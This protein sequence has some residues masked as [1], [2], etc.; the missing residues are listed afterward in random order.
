MIMDRA[1]GWCLNDKCED[2]LKGVF[3]INSAG[4]YRCH[5][6]LTRGK[7]ES[8]T[9]WV[10]GEGFGW[11][12]VRVEY[13]FTPPD[14]KYH[15]L[16]IIRDDCR[17][18]GKVYHFR[19]SIVKTDKRATT[20]ATAMLGSLQFVDNLEEGERPSGMQQLISWDDP[21]EKYE[22]DLKE[23]EIRWSKSAAM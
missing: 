4:H 20:I 7:V 19:S 10:E 23:L 21:P 17:P 1:V 16:A 14:E 3:L 13:N 15:G 8:E 12:E 22:K 9:G 5:I 2:H 18:E 11:Y 6:C